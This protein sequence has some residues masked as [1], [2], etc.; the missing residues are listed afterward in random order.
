MHVISVES[1][2]KS[3]READTLL[4]GLH[5]EAAAQNVRL[6]HW[7]DTLSAQL[8]QLRDSI[9]QARHAANGVSEL[10]QYSR[11]CY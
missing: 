11:A 1:A 10:S 7:N 5:R 4:T 6:A 3:I 2:R 8:Q 9:A